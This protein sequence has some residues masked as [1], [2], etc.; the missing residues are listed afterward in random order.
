MCA[1]PSTSYFEEEK[2]F[3]EKYSQLSHYCFFLSQNKWDGEELL[4]DTIYKALTNY[5]S[6]NSWTVSL[7]KKIAYHNW[8]DKKRRERYAPIQNINDTFVQKDNHEE[9]EALVEMLL[10]KMTMK[11]LA[12]FLLK[13]VFRYKIVEIADICGLSEV[14]VK[15][16]LH[17]S[18]KHLDSLE[19]T[20][21]FY[22]NEVPQEMNSEI[23]KIIVSVIKADDPYLLIKL[24]PTLFKDN[25]TVMVL[26]VKSLRSSIS[27]SYALS[28]AA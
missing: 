5:G 3:L 22:F 16:L 20:D 10:S 7:L 26:P 24:V 4:Q 2:D 25:R 11:Q 8:I 14:A 28:M 13:D 27:P 9:I 23:V 1:R 12:V 15:A 6:S 19:Y 17:R 21:E 18:R